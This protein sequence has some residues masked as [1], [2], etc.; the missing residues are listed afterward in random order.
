MSDPQPDKKDLQGE[1]NYEATRRYDKSARE[2][3]ESGSVD[4]AAAAAAPETA[5][6]AEEME[7]A[8]QIG[9]SHSKGEDRPSP[10]DA[11]KK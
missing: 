6:E 7:R 2:F 9:K 5:Q 10:G 1:G 11:A 3:V 4:D 8:E